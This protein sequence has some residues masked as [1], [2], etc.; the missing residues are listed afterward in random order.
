ML[1][2]GGNFDD[3]QAHVDR[4]KSHAVNKG[5]N[6]ARASSL[7]AMVWRRQHRFE[8]VKSEALHTLDLFERL[9]AAND[10]EAVRR[11]LGQIDHDARGMESDLV[12]PM[13]RMTM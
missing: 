5:H 13:N 3:A 4:A 7:Q 2:E 1:S 12:P 11:L 9:G 8:E 10:A 6:S